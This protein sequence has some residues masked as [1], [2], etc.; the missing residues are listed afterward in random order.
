MIL[1]LRY[2]TETEESWFFLCT[3]LSVWVWPW[4]NLCASEAHLQK[5]GRFPMSWWGYSNKCVGH[6][7]APQ[8]HGEG[9]QRVNINCKDHQESRTVI[10]V[11]DTGTCWALV[12]DDTESLHVGME[13]SFCLHCFNSTCDYSLNVTLQNTVDRGTQ[14]KESC[15]FFSLRVK[16]LEF[17]C[18]VCRKCRMDHHSSFFL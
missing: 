1:W 4:T 3:L 10:V 9:D 16:K 8:S 15:A 18:N 13:G 7:G 12:I 14:W 11:K 2:E 6:G 5:R 17:Y